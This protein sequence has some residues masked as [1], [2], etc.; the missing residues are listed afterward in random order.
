MMG[1]VDT[2]EQQFLPTDEDRILR[3]LGPKAP[4]YLRNGNRVRREQ[5]VGMRTYTWVGSTVSEQRDEFQKQGPAMLGILS[6]I[7]PT[8]DGRVNIYAFLKQL[9]RS[10]NFPDADK[11]VQ[12]PSSDEHIDPAME[13]RVMEAGHSVEPVP[14]EKYALHLRAHLLAMIAARQAG[15]ADTLVAHMQKTAALMQAEQQAA[16]AAQMAALVAQA[17]G[18]PGNGGAMQSGQVPVA[19]GG[20]V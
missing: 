11:V 12:T 14:G 10:F 19:V 8:P 1:M 17:Q 16:Q 7:P 13:H 4:A 5:M 6:K 3:A 18:A 15:W 9:Y 2:T 20:G